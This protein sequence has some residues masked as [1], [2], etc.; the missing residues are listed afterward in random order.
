M[1]IGNKVC[2]FQ[3]IPSTNTH[4]KDHISQFRHGDI[5]CAK[6]QTAGRGRRDRFWLSVEGNLHLSM[7]LRDES[8]SHPFEVVMR[9]SVALI[10]VLR[11][12]RVG[13]IIKYPNDILV[14]HKKIAGMLIEKLED[15]YV[16]GIGLNVAMD[17]V[18]YDFRP[19]S[20]Y[21]ETGKQYDYRDVLSIF[22]DIYNEL[23]EFSM[24]KLYKEYIRYSLVIGHEVVIE[25]E[26]KTVEDIT[27]TGELVL[28]DGTRVT[29]NEVTLKELY[30]E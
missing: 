11:R 29:A 16:V 8:I 3:T 12:L 14:G 23:E 6:I 24:E 2:F 21:M 27:E 15:A 30:H 4:I 18:E 17:T 9:S 22:I 1:M 28:S 26:Y 19:T 20:I 13:A 10:Y 25:G 5:V 7:C